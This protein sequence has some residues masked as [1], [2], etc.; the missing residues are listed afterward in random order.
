MVPLSAIARVRIVIILTLREKKITMIVVLHIPYVVVLSQ[1]EEEQVSQDCR[2]EGALRQSLPREGVFS[3]GP[4]IC[5]RLLAVEAERLPPT[6]AAVDNIIMRCCHRRAATAIVEVLRHHGMLQ[7]GGRNRQI[8]H[9]MLERMMNVDLAMVQALRAGGVAEWRVTSAGASSYIAVI[10]AASVFDF[11]TRRVGRAAEL[12]RRGVVVVVKADPAAA[13][14][15]VEGGQRLVLRQ[16]LPPHGHGG[17]A[18]VS[19]ART[20][21]TSLLTY[22]FRM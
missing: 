18:L 13:A 3:A 9:G 10:V 22:L 2:D 20:S 15:V 16:F 8:F 12:A 11:I 19:L 1:I 7:A 5:A 21:I 4:A 17:Y 6:K 14:G